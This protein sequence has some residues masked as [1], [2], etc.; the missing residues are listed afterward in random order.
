MA[1]MVRYV[2][3]NRRIQHSSLKVDLCLLPDEALL[4]LG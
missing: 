4:M 1:R 3:F 2:L